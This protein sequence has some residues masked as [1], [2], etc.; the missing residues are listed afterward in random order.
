MRVQVHKARYNEEPTSVD[1]I[2]TRFCA[3]VLFNGSDPAVGNGHVSTLPEVPA[4]I[5]DLAV[6]DENVVALL[7]RLRSGRASSNGHATQGLQ[8][9]ASVHAGIIAPVIQHRNRNRPLNFANSSSSYW[10]RPEAEI[11]LGVSL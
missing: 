11:S 1:Y 9:V 5:T 4:R 10:S 7:A 3:Y 2:A 6:L 8:E